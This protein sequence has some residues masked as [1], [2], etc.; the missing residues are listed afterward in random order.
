MKKIILMLAVCTS[1]ILLSCGTKDTV[2][3]S[4]QDFAANEEKNNK[5]E[6]SDEKT[7]KVEISEELDGNLE[8]DL[9][10][11]NKMEFAYGE[12]FRSLFKECMYGF[13]VDV[14]AMTEDQLIEKYGE[15][16]GEEAGELF[17]YRD[18]YKDSMIIIAPQHECVWRM[19]RSFAS[20]FKSRDIANSLKGADY[21][22]IE[23]KFDEY[24]WLM[25]E[26]W[27]SDYTYQG[28][29]DAIGAEGI[30]DDIDGKSFHV[31]WVYPEQKKALS[32]CFYLDDGCLIG[33]CLDNFNY[34]GEY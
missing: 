32:A 18:D 34:L 20:V 25:D 21:S 1:F 14:L 33:V 31:F 30:V 13:D 15:P 23:G 29:V 7:E 11:N 24:G 26:E 10:G 22:R 2:E 6:V 3:S 9:N 12:D 16:D 4:Q 17:W 5:E 27:I 19:Q 28:I 8:D